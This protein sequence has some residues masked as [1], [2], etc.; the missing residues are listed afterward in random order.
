MS[1]RQHADTWSEMEAHTTELAAAFLH[2]PF[3]Q[4]VHLQE[5]ASVA[6]IAPF[7]SVPFASFSFTVKT[8]MTV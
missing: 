3:Y 2:S 4:L 7:C 6:N 8:I 5:R 1:F